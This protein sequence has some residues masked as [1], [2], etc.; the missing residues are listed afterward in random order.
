MGEDVAV[1]MAGQPTLAFDVYSA[2]HE[3]HSFLERVR[4]DAGA[5]AKLAHL[6]APA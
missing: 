1:G 2:E 3:R 5:D 4:I 6:L